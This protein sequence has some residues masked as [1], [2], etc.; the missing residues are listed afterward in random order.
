[1]MAFDDVRT[2]SILYCVMFSSSYFFFELP[3]KMIIIEKKK[4]IFFIKNRSFQ[5][6]YAF[7]PIACLKNGD[8]SYT[9][10]QFQAKTSIEAFRECRGRFF[11][12]LL[13]LTKFDFVMCYL[14]LK[15]FRF[16]NY[17]LKTR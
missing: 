8:E 13:H 1:M 15:K 16:E 17:L 14:F 11:T 3:L 7:I 5:L 10:Y 4:I 6:Y 12:F 2:V 9:Q